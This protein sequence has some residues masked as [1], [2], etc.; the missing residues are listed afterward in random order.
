MTTLTVDVSDELAARVAPMQRWLPTILELTLLGFRTPAIAT[1]TEIVEFLAQ[2]PSSPEILHYQV[3]ERA[4]T[5]MRQLL[6]LNR[7]GLLS[8]L[9][10]LELDE[11]E[12]IQHII[13]MFNIGI[14]LLVNK[15]QGNP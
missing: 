13:I 8:E 9:E 5:R 4:Q 6:A 10:Q 7:D 2:N 14:E 1:V 12:K 11:M 3:S 15:E